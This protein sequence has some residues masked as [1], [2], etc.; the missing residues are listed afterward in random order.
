MLSEFE[1]SKEA[2]QPDNRSYYLQESALAGPV[3]CE[4]FSEEVEFY[5]LHAY[6]SEWEEVVVCER[7]TS[8]NAY[9][10]H[11]TPVKTAS[12]AGV[13]KYSTSAGAILDIDLHGIDFHENLPK[14]FC[15]A[16][17]QSQF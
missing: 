8:K 3:S 6:E 17:S 15:S 16:Q 10:S 12:V 9:R 1:M 4:S 7:N 2:G 5:L 14:L 13:G 11:S